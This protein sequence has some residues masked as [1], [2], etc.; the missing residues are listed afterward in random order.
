MNFQFYVTF[1]EITLNKQN[2]HSRFIK[3]S[4]IGA[5]PTKMLAKVNCL[6]GTSDFLSYFFPQHKVHMGLS[7]SF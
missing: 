5:C 6:S 7:R 4:S 2:R 1:H 3:Y